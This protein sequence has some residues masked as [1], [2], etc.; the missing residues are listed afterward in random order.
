MNPNSV[1]EKKPMTFEEYKH[2]VAEAARYY[3]QKARDYRLSC[4]RVEKEKG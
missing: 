2:K 4:E 1:T 3:R